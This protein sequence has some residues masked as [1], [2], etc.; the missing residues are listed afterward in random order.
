MVTS[1]VFAI[2]RGWSASW[3]N[4]RKVTHRERW[5]KRP[6]QR[7]PWERAEGRFHARYRTDGDSRRRF[8]AVLLLG[9]AKTPGFGLA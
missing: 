1:R 7:I 6:A 8:E 2:R 4:G 9:H 3:K 5:P